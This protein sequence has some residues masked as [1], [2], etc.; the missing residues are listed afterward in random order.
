MRPLTKG[1]TRVMLDIADEN[2]RTRHTRSSHDE[3]NNYIP[4][5][6]DAGLVE[7]GN[8][9]YGRAHVLTQDGQDALKQ[10]K[11]TFGDLL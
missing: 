2:V 1:E 11:C 7:R 9:T 5:L 4:A 3:W 10:A 6:I 8:A